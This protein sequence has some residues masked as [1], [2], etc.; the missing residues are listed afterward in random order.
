MDGPFH[1]G[2]LLA[3]HLAGKGSSGG[4][5]R[6][7]MP[8]QHRE[9]FAMLPMALLAD[10]TADGWP[11]AGV[12]TGAPGFIASPDPQ[13]L[14]IAAAAAA[15]DLALGANVGLLGL[16][17]STRRR[18]RANGFVCTSGA[19]GF[20]LAIEQSFGNCPR[21]IHLRDVSAGL[22]QGGK[23][24]GRLHRPALDQA[25]LDEGA[26]R[27]I[28]RADTFFV[29]T[30]GGVHGADISHR[31]GEPG[32]VHIAGNTLTVPDFNGNRYYNTLGNM[33]MDDRAALLFIDYA[34][35]DLLHLQ[36]RTEV[37]WD[38][39]ASTAAV[40]AEFAGFPG[41]ERLWRFHVE[42]SGL[43]R[44]ALALRWTEREGA[45]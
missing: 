30:T 17:F 37:L 38:G 4:A 39:A 45:L 28:A 16:D 31:G 18:N 44:G 9:F 25:G 36:G 8:D 33:L 21:Y 27:M 24:P 7:Y 40:A 3:Q 34:S 41:A 1:E 13:T 32:F 14:R 42:R 6:D 35:G 19:D 11:R 12:L 22:E 10:V 2:E 29:A 15:A 5:I 26:R 23:A 43:Q 20:T